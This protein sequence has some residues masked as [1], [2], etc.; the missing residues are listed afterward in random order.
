MLFG[1][2]TVA[3][4]L[5]RSVQQPVLVRSVQQSVLVRSVQQSVLASLRM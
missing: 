5:V 3:G 2:K 4:V 1:N